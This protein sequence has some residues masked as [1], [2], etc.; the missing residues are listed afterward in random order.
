[1]GSL[2]K[3]PSSTQSNDPWAAQRP[4]LKEGFRDASQA[5]K[6]AKR[7]SRSVDDLTANMT[8]G[9]TAALEGLTLSGDGLVPTPPGAILNRID[10]ISPGET[11]GLFAVTV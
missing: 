8:D 1:M 5:K 10:A 6:R 9:Q 4:Y 11:P 3:A 7:I 2:F